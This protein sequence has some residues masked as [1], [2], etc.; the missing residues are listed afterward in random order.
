[1]HGCAM[2]DAFCERNACTTGDC[3]MARMGLQPPAPPSEAF[4]FESWVRERW[5]TPPSDLELAGWCGP[6]VPFFK[7]CPEPWRTLF[8]VTT[9]LAGETGEVIEHVK[10]LVRDGKLD[11]EKLKLELGD[12]HHYWTKLVQLFGFTVAEVEQ[13]NVTKLRVRD[14][15]VNIQQHF[16]EGK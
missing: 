12:Q 3:A 2:S 15:A 7:G 16:A 8:I 4:D 1:M 5:A 11:R 6:E 9:G 14:A 13:A 10:K